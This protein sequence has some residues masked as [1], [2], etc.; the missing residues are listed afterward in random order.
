MEVILFF[1]FTRS[2]SIE[3]L[4]RF[5][6]RI[7]NHAQYPANMI[8][9]LNEESVQ[10]YTPSPLGT[11]WLNQRFNVICQ[12]IVMWNLHGNCIGFLKSTKTVVL[13]GKFQPQDYIINVNKFQHR[14]PLY[15]IG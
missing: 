8:T 5:C 13:R 15:E 3:K 2:S 4:F 14:Q 7:H 9:Y 10:S 6:I 1:H 11:N 12:R